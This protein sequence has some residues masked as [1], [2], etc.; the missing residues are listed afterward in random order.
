MSNEV[1]IVFR[2]KD[3]TGGVVG[4]VTKGL[5]GITNTVFSLKG[6]LAGVG[7][8]LV[9][10]SFVDAASTSEQL[11]TRLSVLLGSVEEGNR[12]FKDMS[13]FA[14][15]VPFEYEEI[16]QSATML[17]GILKG[18][19]DEIN[20]WMPLIGDLAATSGLSI[21]ETTE[22]VQRMLSAGAASADKFRERGIN[23][24]LGFQSGV[25]YSAEQT[26][27][28]LIEAW[29]EAGSKF[30]GATGLLADT[31]DGQTSMMKDKWFQFRNAVMDAGI[32]DFMKALAKT[33]ND[34]VGKALKDVDKISA[35]TSSTMISGL[36]GI[37][38]A[39]GFVADMFRGWETIIAG[40][41]H[42]YN[43]FAE[44]VIES[45]LKEK[46]IVN[47]IIR[48]I[49]SFLGT[50]IEPLAVKNLEVSLLGARLESE[51]TN[52]E[53]NKLLMTPMP[54][55]TFEDFK[56]RVI[57]YYRE[58]K[59]EA[60]AALKSGSGDG[61]EKAGGAEIDITTI[62]NE[63]Q[64]RLEAFRE[65]YALE[66]DLLREKYDTES[67]ML[68]DQ[69]AF[70]NLTEEQYLIEK[71]G[72]HEQYET[73]I[74]DVLIRENKKRLRDSKNTYANQLVDFNNMGKSLMGAAQGT[75]RSLFNIGKALSL[76]K[77]TMDL[78]AAVMAT[79]KNAG[80]YPFG[81]IPAAIMG[82]IGALQISKIAG[83]QYQAHAGITRVPGNF[84]ANLAEGER[85]LTAD[86][87]KDL[88]EFLSGGSGG[89]VSIENM[90]VNLKFESLEGLRNASEI[91]LREVIRDT[92]IP[93][94]DVLGEQG[95]TLR[96]IET[97]EQL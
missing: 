71:K 76:A 54:S 50:D 84:S 14:G 92:L 82:G 46:I 2:A 29:T 67:A 38:S 87:N 72:L 39:A 35:E 77:A 75:S 5:R 37:M 85:V 27:D 7:V 20:E 94:F 58:I 25:S 23:A 32:F 90:E 63:L 95:Y 1:K 13:E 55:T 4:S 36:L 74:S 19:V 45:F 16:M 80:G 81:I 31:W 28:R 24:M 83:T 79:Y 33:L 93:A 66:S 26:R 6:A 70:G 86:Q 18:G 43:K 3:L 52:A 68:A 17:S 56:N 41:V 62:Q 40:A 49:N 48:E 8:G 9:A 15:K 53:L 34:D 64:L 65:S 12:L 60:K 44:A 78:P 22:Q 59:S 57:S 89:G 69:L 91:E 47:D 10:K 30:K 61:P 11:Q 51:K 96:R 73:D 88:T 97:S 42:L 21:Q